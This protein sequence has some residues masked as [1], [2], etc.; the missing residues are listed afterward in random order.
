MLSEARACKRCRKEIPAER[1][2]ALPETQ[3]CV[4]CSGE[5]G[6]DFIVFAIPETT[7]KVGSL[8][9]NYGGWTVRKKR[10]EI[11]PLD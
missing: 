9:K 11:I 5:V 10:R 2:E 4:R 7:S 6:S 1:I 3:L 8:K